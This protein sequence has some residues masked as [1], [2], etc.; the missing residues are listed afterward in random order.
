M[1]I[2]TSERGASRWVP[3]FRVADAALDVVTRQVRLGFSGFLLLL[4]LSLIAIFWSD[5]W[6][7][8]SMGFSLYAAARLP[9]GDRW[10]DGISNGSLLFVAVMLV[11]PLALATLRVMGTRFP[12]SAYRLRPQTVTWFHT[13]I[14]LPFGCIALFLEVSMRTLSGYKF[15]GANPPEALFS[16]RL[17]R[18]IQLFGT[19]LIDIPRYLIDWRVLFSL[20][21]FALMAYLGYQRFPDFYNDYWLGSILADID[22]FYIP[23]SFAERGYLGSRYI[24][25]ETKGVRREVTASLNSFYDSAGRV[26]ASKEMLSATVARTKELVANLFSKE[27]IGTGDFEVRFLPDHSWALLA[28]LSS[29]SDGH[30][31]VFLPFLDDSVAEVVEARPDLKRR[32]VFIPKAEEPWIDDW[33]KEEHRLLDCFASSVP[34]DGAGLVIV[35]GELDGPT[36]LVLPIPQL[37]SRLVE[38]GYKPEMI[39]D[40]TAS[41]G[42]K[43]T[44]RFL[45]QTK[46][47]LFAVNQWLV[48]NEPCS[49]VISRGNQ[50]GAHGQAWWEE[51]IAYAPT[52]LRSIR[53]FEAALKFIRGIGGFNALWARQEIL[54]R[55]FR[56]GIFTKFE[57]VGDTDHLERSFLVT[58]KPARPYHWKADAHRQVEQY[59]LS[60]CLSSYGSELLFTA[61]FPYYL[62]LWRVNRICQML[63]DAVEIW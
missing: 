4:D 39:I 56:E 55:K 9:L 38:K 22:P 51:S 23:S 13:A 63:N 14:I 42:N 41:V 15:S 40:G 28:A 59:G 32:S 36:G 34:M 31:I 57:V 27:Q 44:L 30:R 24:S 25:P 2:T 52:N 45:A 6:K 50:N 7:F 12:I 60:A 11:F 16:P 54:S 5:V 53:A 35:T 58:V 62:N 1:P 20:G 3:S 21:F 49:V 29:V 33:S 37:V 43:G 46:V 17:E 18:M 10:R 61:T 48:S 19:I 26:T 47:Y 8:R